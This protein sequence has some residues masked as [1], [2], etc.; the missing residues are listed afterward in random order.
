M[1]ED[2]DEE[3]GV[4][5]WREFRRL[6]CTV[7]GCKRHTLEAKPWCTEH[8]MESPYAQLVRERLAARGLLGPLNG[9]RPT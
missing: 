5:L 4:T 1:T 3:P 6:P 9:W 2:E 7:P 8:V